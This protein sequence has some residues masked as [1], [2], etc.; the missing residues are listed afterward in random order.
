MELRPA[1][2]AAKA[3]IDTLY[4]PKRIKNRLVEEVHY[5]E[6]AGS[7]LITVG[8]EVLKDKDHGTDSRAHSLYTNWATDRVFKIVEVQSDGS[9]KHMVHRD[10]SQAH[11]SR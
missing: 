5:D 6:A 7:W 3:F 9:I 8:F 2:E 11:P 1:V 10:V 4:D